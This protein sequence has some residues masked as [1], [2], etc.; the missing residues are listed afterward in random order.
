MTAVFVG[1]EGLVFQGYKGVLPLA[2][3]L[4]RGGTEWFYQKIFL[5]LVC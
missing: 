1:T 3:L 5:K 4:E 2:T